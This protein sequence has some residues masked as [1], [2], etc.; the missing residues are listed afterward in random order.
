M[1]KSLA[2]PRGPH[3]V[4][5]RLAVAAAILVSAALIQLVVGSAAVTLA[6]LGGLAVLKLR[7]PKI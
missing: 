2:A 1:M 4:V 5:D 6:Y 3:G 7:L